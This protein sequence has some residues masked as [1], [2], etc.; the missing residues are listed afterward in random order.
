MLELNQDSHERA[1]EALL[2]YVCEPGGGIL[3]GRWNGGGRAAALIWPG[4]NHTTKLYIGMS[5]GPTEKRGCGA[6]RQSTTGSI[7]PDVSPDGCAGGH[8]QRER[9][10]QGVGGHTLTRQFKMA[11]EEARQ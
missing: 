1:C 8:A 5:G 6:F 7:S 11:E 3:G 10:G 4:A 9:G 2:I